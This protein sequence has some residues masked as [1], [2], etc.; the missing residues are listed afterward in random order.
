[1]T[2]FTVIN[3]FKNIAFDDNKKP[4][5]ICDIDL[6]FIR[7]L[8]SYQYYYDS[9]KNDFSNSPQEL[10]CM[11][12]ELMRTSMAIGLIKHTDKQGFFE[13][14]KKVKKLNGKLIFLTAR[15]AFSHDKTVEQ[16]KKAGLQNPEEYEIHYTGNTMTKGNYIKKYNLLQDYN[17]HI[18]IDDYP[19][20]LDSAFKIYPY[21]NCYL[22]KYK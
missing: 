12:N 3:T 19:E 2:K 8:Y 7:P 16:L 20:Y 4:I 11:A 13:M 17:H 5:V 21:M 15:S 18:F 10:S 14:L 6:T 9:L 1:M 22:F